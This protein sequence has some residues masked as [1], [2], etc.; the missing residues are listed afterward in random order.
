MNQLYVET[1]G[2]KTFVIYPF[3]KD[4][5]IDKV[6]L[7]MLTNN[8]IPGLADAVFSQMDEKKLLKYDITGRKSAEE[9]LEGK[10]KKQDLLDILSGIATSFLSAEE[11]MLAPETIILDKKGI[12][13]NTDSGDTVLVCLPLVSIGEK[14][15]SPRDFLLTLLEEADVEKRGNTDYLD[16]ITKFIEQSDTLRFSEFRELLD[17]LGGKRV[18]KPKTNDAA[19]AF[20]VPGADAVP[21]NAMNMADNAGY[22]N[23]G[24]PQ[25]PQ[26]GFAD[27]NSRQSVSMPQ[28]IPRPNAQAEPVQPVVSPMQQQAVVQPVMPQTNAFA[29]PGQNG[30]AQGAAALAAQQAAVVQ[31][32]VPNV[33]APV[34]KDVSLLYLLQHYNKDNAAAY[35]A[36]KEAKKAGKAA[37]DAAKKAGK[38]AEKAAKQ[39]EKD[40]EKAAKEAEK[41]AK[42]AAKNQPQ[43]QPAPQMYVPQEPGAAMQPQQ[44]YTPQN[45][46]DSV[47]PQMQQAK[48][49]M[50]VQPQVPPQQ[51]VQQQMPEQPQ[52]ADPTPQ[53]PQEAESD[54]TILMEELDDSTVLMEE[55][56]KIRVELTR[57]ETGDTIFMTKDVFRLGRNSSDVDLNMEDN[58]KVSHNHA[59]LIIR[60]DELYIKDLGS[61]NHTYINENKVEDEAEELLSDGDVIRLGNEEFEVHIF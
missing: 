1:Q 26:G 42:K 15:Q 9:L 29:V 10:V 61:K 45:A 35:K 51:P 14:Q 53:K 38:D 58:R 3:D 47:Q 33:A 57:K 6:T 12:F 36:Q 2:E 18:R 41:A 16:K 8:H 27:A 46:D 44:V 25:M 56:P 48:Q 19:S 11:Y 32:N 24:A 49:Q 55:E 4:E 20:A 39:A 37:Q 17:Q 43:L 60:E 13:M 30:V 52:V 5:K 50:P 23:M 22:A 40:A 28:P 7:G 31:Q 34:E 59:E 21:Q 54:E